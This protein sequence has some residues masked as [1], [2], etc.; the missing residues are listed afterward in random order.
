MDDKE[1]FKSTIEDEINRLYNQGSTKTKKQGHK[2][3]ASM[4]QPDL[5]A[6]NLLNARLNDKEMTN[7]DEIMSSTKRHARCKVETNTIDQKPDKRYLSETEFDSI[8]N[9]LYQ[10][11]KVYKDKRE[12]AI[13]KNE[14]DMLETHTFRPEIS[15][16]SKLIVGKMSRKAHD[17]SVCSRYMPIYK[18]ER[19]KMIQNH[20]Q[21]KVSQIK[22]EIQDRQDKIKAEE[23]QILAQV[24]KKTS[25]EKYDHD[26]FME[27]IASQNKAY[28]N[29]LES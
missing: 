6:K 1:H 20:K 11:W 27:N 3:I 26:E 17:E 25:A 16:N 12:Q 7:N 5:I 14:E 13:L 28:K 19:L 4:Q 8:V 29:K 2:R 18:E 22:K 21:I 24:A 9:R 15:E 10:F 23:D